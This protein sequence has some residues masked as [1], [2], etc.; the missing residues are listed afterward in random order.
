MPVRAAVA[1][2]AG[3]HEPQRVEQLGRRAEGRSHAG[4]GGALV[5]RERGGDIAHA[6]H[7][8]LLGLRHA[9]AG[10][11]GERLKVAAAAL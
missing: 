6:V 7:L 8:R 4:Y 3:I 2:Q 11:G 9:A 5:Q 1:G 10:V